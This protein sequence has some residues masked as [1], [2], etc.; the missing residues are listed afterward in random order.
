MILL[1]PASSKSSGGG[2]DPGE[3]VDERQK[4]FFLYNLVPKFHFV[5]DNFYKELWGQVFFLSGSVCGNA[6]TG[7]ERSLHSIPLENSLGTSVWFK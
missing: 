7:L 4:V 3:E 1:F 2:R 5:S 6:K